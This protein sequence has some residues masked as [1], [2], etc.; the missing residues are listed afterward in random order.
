MRP[1][2]QLDAEKLRITRTVLVALL[3]TAA[4]TQGCG[5][6]GASSS[7][8]PPPPP[9]PSIVVTV[10]PKSGS[11]LLG[12]ATTF[13]AKVTNTTDTSVSWSVNG[14][15]GGSATVGTITP[16]GAYTAPAD[17]PSPATV[18]VT[19]DEPCGRDEIRHGCLDDH[20]RHHSL[21][22]AES[23]ER[24]TRRESRIS[25]GSGEQR[26]SGYRGAVERV[27]CGVP[28]RLRGRGY[29]WELHGTGNSS[30]TSQC[31]ADGAKR[32]RSFQAGFGGGD[33]HQHIFAATLSVIERASGRNGDDCRDTDAGSG[34]GSQQR[35][36]MVAE[37]RWLQRNF[38]WNLERGDDAI[39]R[40][41]RHCGFG[42]V[43]GASNGAQ[44][45]QRDGHGNSAGGSIEKS[46]GHADDSAR[47]QR[48]PF[49]LDG[50]AGGKSSSHADGASQR[51]FE[52]RR[53]LE[54]EWNCRRQC[55]P[56]PDL[57]R[58][59]ESLSDRYEQYF[60]ANGFPRS[61]SDP[62]AESRE[63]DGG[64][65]GGFHEEREL[66]DY[67]H[68]S[69]A[70]VGPASEHDTCDAGCAGVHG[71]GAGYR[72]PKRGVAGSGHGLCECWHLRID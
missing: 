11:V 19:A 58:G 60:I 7:M 65:R 66:T 62:L 49:S 53:E 61:R 8:L 50:N 46:A 2:A 10:A 45:K 68:Q 44:P 64:E 52:Y 67:G 59:L 14:T 55:K 30:V 70:R 54:R 33:N 24:G 36:G 22:D 72:Q 29:K 43:H 17:L 42:D 40:R 71:V 57:R 34:L 32:G 51:N 25:Y 31:D 6:A 47:S 18:Q 9:P 35:A 26:A 69:R 63:R 23:S 37:R 1:L 39:G 13:T 12:N 3:T 4:W 41:K 27:G 48:E 20:E 5:A 56:R 15:A 28:E 38:V 21:D 16:D